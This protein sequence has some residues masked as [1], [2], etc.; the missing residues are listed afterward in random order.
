MVAKGPLIIM[1]HGLMTI[2]AKLRPGFWITVPTGKLTAAQVEAVLNY[3]SSPAP[4]GS[5][6]Q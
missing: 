3:W 4:R 6:P 5:A 2:D 1:A